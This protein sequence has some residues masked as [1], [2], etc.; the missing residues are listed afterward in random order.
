MDSHG[1]QREYN[2]S[3]ETSIETE[4]QKTV[5]LLDCSCDV[6]QRDRKERER[7]VWEG[8][9]GCPKAQDGESLPEG[10]WNQLST[11]HF[12]HRTERPVGLLAYL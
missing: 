5:L 4:L 9:P 7:R 12:G 2:A 3:E 6:S 10:V 1:Q 8:N 11:W